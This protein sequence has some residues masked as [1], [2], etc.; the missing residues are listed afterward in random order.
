MFSIFTRVFTKLLQVRMYTGDEEEG[1]VGLCISRHACGKI[2]LA[3]SML[4]CL[5]V[6]RSSAPTQHISKSLP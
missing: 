3:P 6:H 1:D 2:S 5:H 4:A